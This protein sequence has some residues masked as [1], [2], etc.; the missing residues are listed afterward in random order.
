[1]KT[2]NIKRINKTKLMEMI[3]RTVHEAEGPCEN[4]SASCLA[5]VNLRV[6]DIA[7]M[8]DESV[9]DGEKQV[10]REHANPAFGN[11][12]GVCPS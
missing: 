3:C 12:E 6:C 11:R 1:M 10:E 9:E 8:I 7:Y 5:H 2:P 4:Q